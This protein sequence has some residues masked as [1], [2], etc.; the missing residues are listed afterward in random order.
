MR[1]C[2]LLLPNKDNEGV[3]LA[4]EQFDVLEYIFEQFKGYTVDSMDIRGA[5]EMDDACKTIACDVST[6]VIVCVENARLGEL[7]RMIPFIAKK[8]R[9]ESLYF[10]VSQSEVEFVK[11]SARLP[12]GGM[13]FSGKVCK[14]SEAGQKFMTDVLRDFETLTGK[15]PTISEF[16]EAFD[17][18]NAEHNR[19]AKIDEENRQEQIDNARGIVE[20]ATR[21]I[22]RT[23]WRDGF[24]E[25]A[26]ELSKDCVRNLK[27]M[28][29][30]VRLYEHKGNT[31]TVV[32]AIK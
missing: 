19:Q 22:S 23:V 14:G 21:T 31:D 2:T 27:L 29:F 25:I 10:E 26:G 12:A 1:K 17:G 15:P 4:P 24:V 9:Q 32:Y 16:S 28:G 20:T 11:A 3:S 30:K 6:R 8:L 13:V 7:R 18:C 5:Y